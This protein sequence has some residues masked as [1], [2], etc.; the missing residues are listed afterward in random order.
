M[1]WE[2]Y[3]GRRVRGGLPGAQNKA[4]RSRDLP[5]LLLPDR[6]LK[7]AVLGCRADKEGVFSHRKHTGCPDADADGLFDYWE[8]PSEK[9]AQVLRD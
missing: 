1:S 9:N 6:S 2:G 7:N 5:A 8:D 4:G 3:V